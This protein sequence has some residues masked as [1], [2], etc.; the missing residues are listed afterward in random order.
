MDIVLLALIGTAI[1]I[2]F[3]SLL[4]KLGGWVYPIL[5]EGFISQWPMVFWG[6]ILSLPLLLMVAPF[7]GEQRFE[8]TYASFKYPPLRL[9]GVI[10]SGLY[11]LFFMYAG[12]IFFLSWQ[13]FQQR[14]RL[15][16]R[17]FTG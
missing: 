16:N 17:I 15:N 3:S 13:R 4:F 7:G 9:A 5:G 10:G 12:T 6:F 2:C 8:I 11:L 1:S 14:N